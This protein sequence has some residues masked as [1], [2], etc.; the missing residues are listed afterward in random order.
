MSDLKQHIKDMQDIVK[1]GGAWCIICGDVFISIREARKHY[2]AEHY[3][4]VLAQCK[5][6]KELLK[7]WV[8][9]P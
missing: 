2:L 6:D 8:D 9:L 7:K 5:G 3:D 4:Y 1:N